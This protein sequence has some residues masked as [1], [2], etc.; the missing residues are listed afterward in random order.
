MS[1][2]RSCLLTRFTCL[3]LAAALQVGFSSIAKLDAQEPRRIFDGTFEGWE[4]DWNHWRIEQ[5]SIVGEIPK[6]KTLG[7]NTWLVWRAGELKDFELQLQFQLSGLAAANSGIQI[8]CQVDSVDHVSGYQADL[9]MGSTWLGRIYDEHGRAMLVERGERVKILPDGK[10]LSKRYAPLHQYPVLYRENRWNDYRIVAIGERIDVYVNGSLFSQ[11]WD[12]QTDQK[13]LSGSLALQLHS[14]PET[15]IAFRNITL[16]TLSPKDAGRLAKFDLPEES[17]SAEGPQEGILPVGPDAKPLNL[18]F[19]SGT[20]DGWKA[21]GNAFDKQPVKQDGISK[22]WP[23]QNSNKQGEYFIGGYEIVQDSGTGTLQSETFKV[24]HPYAGFLFGGGQDNSTRAEVVLHDASGAETKIIAKASGDNREQMRRIAVDLREYQGATISVRIVDENPGGW[25]HLNFDDFRFYDAPPATSLASDAGPRSTF[26]AVL[27]SLVPNKVAPSDITSVANKTLEQMHV[28]EGFSVDLIAAEPEVHQ[29]IAF[30]FDPKGRLW[31]LEGQSYP[32]KRPEGQ[33][34]DRIVIFADNDGDGRFENR[35]VFCEGLNLASGI[36]V[37]HSGVWVGAAPELLFIPDRDGDDSPDGPA[38]VLLDGFG[39]GDTHETLNSFVWGPDGWLYGTQGVFNSSMVGK[40]GAAEQD[41]VYLAAGVWRYDPIEHRFE[42]FAHGTSNPWGLDYDQHGQFFMTHCRSFWGKGGTTHVM[43]GGHYWNQVNGGY[44][45][46]ISNVPIPSSPHLQNFLLA[47][48]RY[49]SGE[50]GAGKPGTG[51]I[52]GGHSHVGTA[53]YLGDNWPKEYR[54][55]LVTHNL[56]GHQLNH[57]INRREAGGY[58]TIHAGNDLMLCSDPAFVGVDLAVGPD[59]ALYMSDW[60]DT[61][62]CHNPGVELWDRG[63]GRIYR[64]KYD[65]TYKPNQR[66][67]T[68]ASDAQLVDALRMSDDWHVRAARG[69]LASRYAG[70]TVPQAL[71]DSIRTLG[72][73]EQAIEPQAVRIRLCALWV[74]ASLRVI[75][76]QDIASSLADPSEI[77]RSWGVRFLSQPDLLPSLAKKETSL[78]V[79]REIALAAGRLGQTHP[80]VTQGWVA[81][82]TLCDQ[83]ENSQDRDLPVILWQSIGKLWSKGNPSALTRAM[84]I[85]DTT[86]LETVRD[87]ILWYAAKTSDA[88]RLALVSKLSKAAD[89]RALGHHLEILEYAIRGQNDLKPNDAWAK[90]AP[91]LY[92]STNPTIRGLAES[93]GAQMGD[94]VLF[95]AVRKRLSKGE[96]IKARS[97]AMDILQRDRSPANL[98]LLLDTLD[99]PKLAAKALTL[100]RPYDDPKIADAVIGRLGNFAPDATAAAMDLLTSRKSLANDLLDALASKKIDR[101]VLSAYYARQMTL[102]SDEKLNER[103]AKEWGQVRNG[104][105][106][107][108][109]QIRKTVNAYRGAPLWAFDAGAGKMHFQK[110]CA[111]CHLPENQNIEIAPKL[112]GTGAKGIEYAIE[113]II[114]PNA[115]IGKDYQARVIRIKDGQ[116]ITG[117]AQ[118]E[119]DSSISIR[120]ATETIQIDKSDVEEFKVSENSFMPIGLLDT[121]DERQRIEL[122]KYLMSL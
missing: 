26:N 115:V 24:T 80:E 86:P 85:A 105:E 111:S 36:E 47:S 75:S 52:Y 39:F 57:Q 79:R 48:A 114:D 117:L 91:M 12:Q 15:R 96:S 17:P 71:V 27:H 94:Q 44:A 120:T 33:G 58:D 46:F 66:D 92:A 72:G 21:V 35:K 54:N 6:G 40:P 112:Q 89:E 61:R 87:S 25:G 5:D 28:P 20:L 3:I 19:E 14:G 78:M 93:V 29:P 4:G 100:V 97:Q 59:G 104:N 101:S 116:V 109:D 34:L 31:V 60:V 64:M 88:G 7:K 95:D 122:L 73:S 18:G 99:E 119:S 11:L 8:R 23:G 38:Q 63:N 10:R 1:S 55:H 70:K 30:A 50:G 108:K 56:H 16:E 67:W 53:I 98:Q 118:A 65:A 103:I 68:K 42:V 76:E 81:I 22:R 37:G 49:D 84:A 2:R 90:L 110:L 9:D 106:A 113:N 83:P 74:L 69:V 51:E 41:R 13:D 107:M 82:A 62:H 43:H 102:L 45:P 32:Q 121:L 77:V